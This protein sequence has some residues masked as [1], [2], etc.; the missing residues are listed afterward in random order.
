MSIQQVH[1][2]VSC[3]LVS[4]NGEG[5]GEGLVGCLGWCIRAHNLVLHQLFSQSLGSDCSNYK[6]NSKK[7]LS[8]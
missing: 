8:P 3:R 1:L 7:V 6:K 4:G 5:N 2:A